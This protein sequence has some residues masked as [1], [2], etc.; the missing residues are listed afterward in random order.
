MDPV[1]LE[2]GAAFAE[3]H[4]HW[5]EELEEGDDEPGRYLV[6]RPEKKEGVEHVKEAKDC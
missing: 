4:I 5:D 6:C 2:L 3:E 1:V